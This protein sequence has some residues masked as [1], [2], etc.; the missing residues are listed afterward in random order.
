MPTVTIGDNTTGVDFTG[1]DD[2]K[3]R[4]AN[5][6]TNFATDNLEPFSWDVGDDGTVCLRF[7]GLSNISGPVTVSA[8][9]VRL[10]LTAELGADAKQMDLRRLLRNWVEAQATANDFSTGNAWQTQLGVGAN[11]IS[12]TV[13][14]TLNVG[15]TTGQYYV[16]S[17]AQL[18]TDVENWI[19][20]VNA[21]D[22][23]LLKPQTFDHLT[24]VHTF[25]SSEGTDGRRPL[26]VFTYTTGA[27]EP[28]RFALF[29]VGR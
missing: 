28:R 14:A 4:S 16:W 15:I 25:G 17:D 8:A 5:P 2:T 21:N 11:D 3:L 24:Q 1:T 10:Y 27:A 6:T 26:L 20:G 12:A 19:N 13:S 7:T 29:G 9:E 22:G 23:W 18:A